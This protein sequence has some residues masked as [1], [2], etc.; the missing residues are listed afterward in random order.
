MENNW[1]VY[2][3]CP[4]I[5]EHEYFI[6][7]SYHFNICLVYPIDGIKREVIKKNLTEKEAYNFVTQLMTRGINLKNIFFNDF[8]CC[9]QPVVY[10]KG[11]PYKR[12][13]KFDLYNC[14]RLLK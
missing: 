11:R 2:K 3:R 4:L 7:S 6:C 1:V 5:L 12:F 13:S 14:I 10:V 8:N 9:P